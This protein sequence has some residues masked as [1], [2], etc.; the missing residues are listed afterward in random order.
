M[1]SCRGPTFIVCFH[2]EFF[3]SSASSFARL[4]SRNYYERLLLYSIYD[5]VQVTMC[6]TCS[7][8]AWI[9]F[10]RFISSFFFL[11][12]HSKAKIPRKFISIQFMFCFDL[13]TQFNVT[14]FLACK[15]QQFEYTNAAMK[16]D[17]HFLVFNSRKL[18]NFHYESWFVRMFFLD[19]KR[20]KQK[21]PR[22]SWKTSIPKWWNDRRVAAIWPI[23]SQ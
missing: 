10:L 22:V 2:C 9:V 8:H 11:I 15:A 3:F 1:N 14:I 4:N 6:S 23:H 7:L 17:W 21:A 5:H 12:C 13:Q 16:C 19:R 18:A 20:K